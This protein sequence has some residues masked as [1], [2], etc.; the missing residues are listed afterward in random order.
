MIV[1][2]IVIV[3][4]IVAIEIKG[5]LKDGQWEWFHPSINYYGN[6][7][8]GNIWIVNHDVVFLSG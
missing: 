5:F 6:Y 7:G 1:I 3:I 4:V 8:G 2:I